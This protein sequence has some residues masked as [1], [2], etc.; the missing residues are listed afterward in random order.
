VAEFTTAAGFEAHATAIAACATEEKADQA[1]QTA[2]GATLAA[3]K[4]AIAEADAITS[5]A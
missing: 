3:A 2:A 4:A 5:T 1:A